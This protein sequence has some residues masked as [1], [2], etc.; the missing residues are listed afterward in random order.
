MIA[1]VGRVAEKKRR[2]TRQTF[3]PRMFRT[4]AIVPVTIQPRMSP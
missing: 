3:H 4:R 1:L 2:A